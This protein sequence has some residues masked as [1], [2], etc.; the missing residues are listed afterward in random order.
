MTQ[1][2]TTL[3]LGSFGRMSWW[4]LIAPAVQ[5]S[6]VYVEW[7]G[8]QGEKGVV[9]VSYTGVDQATP[10]GTVASATGGGAA[11]TVDAASVAGDLVADFAAFTDSGGGSLTLA[12]GAGQTSRQ[13]IEG[14]DLQYDGCGA[15]EE[16]A[17]GA[18][19]TMSWTVSNSSIDGWGILAAA[20]KAAGAGGGTTTT[21]TLTSNAT[22]TDQ[23]VAGA[24]RGST[25]ADA[26]VLSDDTVSS[27][28]RNRLLESLLT[29]SE[30]PTVSTAVVQ[31]L[32]EDAIDVGD[33]ALLF[34][35]RRRLLEDGIDITDAAIASLLSGDVLVRILSDTLNI[36]DAALSAINRSR[37]LESFL[38]LADASL[39]A[40][41][42]FVVLSD[43]LT[44]SD[45]VTDVYTGE[46]L[47]PE[48]VI[49]IG[50]DQPRIDIGGYAV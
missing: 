18:S 31:F 29:I 45:E 14:S 3:T 30:G 21:T 25:L 22:V 40:Q 15:S 20:L 12:A 47:P 50:F 33:S 8:T 10:K 11:I 28:L 49:V 2:G 41:Q 5:T 19:T 44:I 1:L 26:L 32:A 17:S 16:T 9:A 13:E 7:A 37:L 39:S 23:T 38:Q 24:I 43:L 4:E 6:T 46:D 27:A 42:H 34:M 48:P 36:S 35:L